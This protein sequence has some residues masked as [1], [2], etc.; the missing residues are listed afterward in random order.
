[1]SD[2][3]NV[4]NL[5]VVIN[6]PTDD[7]KIG[8]RAYV[9]DKCKYAIAAFETGASQTLHIQ[10]YLQLKRQMKFSSVKNAIPRAHIEKARGN[11]MRN[12]EYVRKGDQPHEE[13]EEHGTAG[14]NYGKDVNIFFELGNLTLQ[15]QRNDLA[16][17]AGMVCEGKS[18]REIA[19]E[20]PETYIKFHKGIQDYKA[21]MTQPRSADTAKEV[22]VHYGPTGTGKTR[23]ATEEHPDAYVY[24]PENGKWFEGYDGHKAVILEEF[25]GQL[26]FGYLLR[27]TDRYPMQVEYKG[28][29]THF[30]ADKIII[31]SPVHPALWYTK[32]DSRDGKMAQLKRRITKIYKFVQLG[33]DQV[34][35]TDEPW[36]EPE[37]LPQFN[38]GPQFE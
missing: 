21:K 2:R 17:V 38:F 7:D 35:V 25:R 5:V 23:V 18:L 30:L 36:P 37:P 31:T 22:I 34:D 8:L 24:G 15:G 9:E 14:I 12:R 28:G 11:P 10:A 6:N 26:T 1:M 16:E 33:Q 3:S 4:T 20:N 27:L 29:M 32:L 13:W 19:E